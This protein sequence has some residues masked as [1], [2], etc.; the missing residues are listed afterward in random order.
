MDD[1]LQ[2]V[3]D[4]LPTADMELGIYTFLSP[5]T[6]WSGTL[7]SRRS[8]VT[9]AEDTVM[10]LYIVVMDDGTVRLMEIPDEKNRRN[11]SNLNE[12]HLIGYCAADFPSF[13]KIMNLYIKAEKRLAILEPI[14]DAE[15]FESKCAE[16][17]AELRRQ[18]EKIDSTAVEDIEGLWSTMIEEMEAG[19]C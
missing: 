4:H 19:I 18:V 14:L 16:E 12:D 9:V 3:K 17:G 6:L 1:I 8:F 15:T 7:K 13:M 2:I 10:G 5:D 11:P